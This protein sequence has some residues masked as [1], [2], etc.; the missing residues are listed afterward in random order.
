MQMLP[1]KEQFHRTLP[2]GSS[3]VR[4]TLIGRELKTISIVIF[5]LM[6]QVCFLLPLEFLEESKQQNKL[7]PCL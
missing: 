6:L 1:Y 4:K 5:F 3:R 2:R 7:Q